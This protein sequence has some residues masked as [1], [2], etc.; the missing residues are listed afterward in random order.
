M[1]ITVFIAK[2]EKLLAG[3]Q[4]EC[5][6]SSSTALSSWVSSRQCAEPNYLNLKNGAA[7]FR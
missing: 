7:I 3:F 5:F 2:L 6:K 1:K 4:S